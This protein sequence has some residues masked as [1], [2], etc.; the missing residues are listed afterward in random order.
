[1][2][3]VDSYSMLIVSKYFHLPFD[4]I[5]VI[6]VCKKFKETTEK[7]RFNPIP[8]KSLKLFPK[9]QT[10]YLYNKNDMKIKGIGNYEI[11]YEIDYGQYL[12]IKDDNTSFHHIIYTSHNRYNYGVTIPYNV[13]TT[14][15]ECFE[16]RSFRDF[17]IPNQITSI[18]SGCF[19]NCSQLRNITLP[20]SLLSIPSDCFIHC[21]LLT[22]VH[23]PSTIQSIGNSCFWYCQSLKTISIPNSVTTI[24]SHCFYYCNQLQS[25]TLPSL[26]TFLEKETFCCCSQLSK[27]V[28]TPSLTL[29]SDRCFSQ[30]INLK[31]ITLP[32]SLKFIGIECFKTCGIESIEVP[33]SI[34]SIGVNCFMECKSLTNIM[35]RSQHKEFPFEVSYYDSILYKQFGIACQRIK[36][37]RSDVEKQSKHSDNKNI[38]YTIPFTISEID[39]NA[40]YH[41]THFESITIPT[42]VTS[43]G[44]NCFRSCRQLTSL[45]IP[46]NV[47]SIGKYCFLECTSLKQLSVPLNNDKNYPFK[48][49]YSDYLILKQCGINCIEKCTFSYN[50]S[51]IFQYKIPL[52]I[53][54]VLNIK[55]F[56]KSSETTLQNNII[57]LKSN[58]L[59]EDIT[60]ITI[61]TS[62]TYLCDDCF[63]GYTKLQS[64]TIPTTVK[65][66]GKHLIDGCISLTEL[67][68]Q[69]DWNNIIVSYD[70][71]LR[72]KS[73]GFMFNNIEYTENDKKIYG[74]VIP[75]I[76]HS[77]HHSY[78]DR[79]NEILHIPTHVTSLDNNMFGDIIIDAY[80]VKDYSKLH[81]IIIP[82]SVQTIPKHCFSSC[83]L[84]THVLLPSSLTSIKKKA[85]SNCFSLQSINVPSSVISIEQYAFEG[86]FS[87]TSITLP[88]SI[89]LLGN[90]CFKGC[91]EL[92]GI[93]NIPE[94]CF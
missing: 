61:P 49:T 47:Q 81:N 6:C 94:R 84:L 36:L 79:S 91:Y 39:A 46:N 82:T 70:D 88:T 72:Y 30:C 83:Y 13:K 42:T 41:E 15:A 8:I 54:L 12:K 65:Y 25:I 67:N 37:T 48:V 3:N 35:L 31:S 40:F 69:G 17:A 38:H 90:K 1:M 18:Q 55:S 11:W 22:S 89:T 29:I 9:I 56:Q 10:Q 62:L 50:D 2:T 78:Y 66:I 80:G 32:L 16:C 20:T 59:S 34:K 77:L 63:K 93:L 64:I 73:N 76:V 23:I 43:I 44:M 85:F 52:G 14:G 57:S 68:Y 28:L 51:S 24:G 87:L 45:S 60:L 27:I 92:K 19:S 86:C 75:S 7:L 53:P 21:S 33:N 26:I 71:H 5:N 4:Y 74:N 58:H